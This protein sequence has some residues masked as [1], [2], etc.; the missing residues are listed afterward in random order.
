VANLRRFDLNL[1][2]SLHPLL[3]QNVVETTYWS[4]AVERDAGHV[5]LWNLMREIARKL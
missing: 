2:L 4:A 1:L 3:H 5:W